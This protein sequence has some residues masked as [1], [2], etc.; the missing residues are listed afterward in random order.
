MKIRN[1]D[2]RVIPILRSNWEERSRSKDAEERLARRFSESTHV[3]SGSKEEKVLAYNHLGMTT[4]VQ[5]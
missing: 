5:K 2:Y 1:S 3:I 4:D